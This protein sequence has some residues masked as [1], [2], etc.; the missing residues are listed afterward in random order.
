VIYAAKLS[1]TIS[2]PYDYVFTKISKFALKALNSLALEFSDK[3]ITYYLLL[4]EFGSPMMTPKLYEQKMGK[5]HQSQQPSIG[6]SPFNGFI[7]TIF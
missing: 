7:C 1:V 4:I 6:V 3:S 2:Y 5:S